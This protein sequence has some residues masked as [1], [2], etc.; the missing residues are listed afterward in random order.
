MLQMFGYL[1]GTR[2]LADSGDRLARVSPTYRNDTSYGN[3]LWLG[4]TYGRH[5]SM[6]LTSIL[7][8]HHPLLYL[9]IAC[10]VLLIKSN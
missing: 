1:S 7:H 4:L 6:G 5:E 9:A 8:V 2:H 3:S 10:G